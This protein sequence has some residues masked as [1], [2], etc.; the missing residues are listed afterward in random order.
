[1]NCVYKTNYNDFYDSFRI[2]Y[3]CASI[4][5]L[6]FSVV[7]FYYK[8]KTNNQIKNIQNF[9]IILMTLFMLIYSV[10]ID[11]YYNIYPQLL[12]TILSDLTTCGGISIIII[13]LYVLINIIPI[14][15]SY[16]NKKLIQIIHIL[17]YLLIFVFGLLQ[18]YVNYN[19]F[20]N[21]KLILYAV[22]L[23]SITLLFNKLMFHTLI[24]MKQNIIY[25]PSIHRIKKYLVV[26]NILS[27]I[28]IIYQ[29]YISI[30]N[31]NFNNISKCNV[32]S[33]ILFFIFKLVSIILYYFFVL[34]CT[35]IRIH[36]PTLNTSNSKLQISTHAREA[37]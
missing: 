16:I 37:L 36:I 29:L 33:S 34:K 14:R 21:I 3:I 6:I 18:N 4:I 13:Y 5:L 8:R 10:D 15:N 17:L 30:Y 7:I 24:Y 32:T 9:N 2:I 12:V 11:G 31:L 1:M 19:I 26:Y 28:I 20:Y 27:S 22:I 23:L 35:K 25:T